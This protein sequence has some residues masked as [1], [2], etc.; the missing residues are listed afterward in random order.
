MSILRTL[1]DRADP[2]PVLLLY[3]NPDLGS[4]LFR[5]ELEL[6]AEH[7]DLEVVDV[8]ED[9][10]DGWG[11]ESGFVDADVL[12][13]HLPEDAHRRSYFVCGPDPMMDAAE[14]ALVDLGVPREQ[15]AME[16]FAL[17]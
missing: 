6:L 10:P 14:Q 3:A 7:L 9:P 16:R 13:R 5:D 17:A 11:G 8:I 15:V 2:R 1:A 4:A 12:R